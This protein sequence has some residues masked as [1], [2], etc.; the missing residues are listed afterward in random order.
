MSDCFHCHIGYPLRASSSGAVYHVTDIGET[1]ACT[2]PENNRPPVHD[3][4]RAALTARVSQLTA[5]LLEACDIAAAQGSF[6][7]DEADRIAQLRQL[8][9]G[10]E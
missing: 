6:H 5:A 8:A 9:E 4:E 10:N 3:S 2:A 1:P 7:P